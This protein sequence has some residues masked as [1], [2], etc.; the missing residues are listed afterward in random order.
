MKQRLVIDPKRKGGGGRRAVEPVAFDRRGRAPTHSF[1]SHRSIRNE[2]R[3][4]HR[5]RGYVDPILFFLNRGLTGSPAG[6]DHRRGDRSLL[7][8]EKAESMLDPS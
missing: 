4:F 5:F 1:P 3:T 6:D 2:Q 7:F 8:P